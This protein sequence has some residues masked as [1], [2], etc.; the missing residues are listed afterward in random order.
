MENWD[1]RETQLVFLRRQQG[2]F[3]V[4]SVCYHP[5]VKGDVL[6][7]RHDDFVCKTAHF[8]VESVCVCSRV[9]VIFLNN[10]IEDWVHSIRKVVFTC[11]CLLVHLM[12][13]FSHRVY[14]KV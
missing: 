3:T 7:V 12:F 5:E 8:V 1:E 9:L 10:G 13:F 11:E 4:E 14:L 6:P 2:E